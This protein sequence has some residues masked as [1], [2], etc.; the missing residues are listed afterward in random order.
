MLPG[1]SRVPFDDLR[2]GQVS[3]PT[4]VANLASS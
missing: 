3:A 1:R 2:T 4:T